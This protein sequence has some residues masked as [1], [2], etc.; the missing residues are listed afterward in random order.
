MRIDKWLWA[1]R[2]YKTRSLATAACKA[3]HVLVN[4]RKVKPSRDVQPGEIVKAQTGEVMRTVRVLGLIDKRVGA[5]LAR[6]YAEDL[7]PPEEYT[8]RRGPDF[9]RG[10]VRPKGTGRPTKKERRA[11]DSL[12]EEPPAGG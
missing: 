2:L 6:D 12:Q 5:A 4:E 9:S 11:I 8:K 10:I 3:G 1:V 7:T